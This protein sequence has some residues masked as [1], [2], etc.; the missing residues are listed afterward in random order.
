[1]QPN[2]YAYVL[3]DC[4][5]EHARCKDIIERYARGDNSVTIEQFREAKETV[6]NLS[7]LINAAITRMNKQRFRVVKP[8]E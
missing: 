3:D 7:T 2:V 5:K 6:S 1:M 8:V 4:K